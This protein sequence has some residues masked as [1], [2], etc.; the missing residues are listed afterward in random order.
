[1]G[2]FFYYYYY[3]SL[4]SWSHEKYIHRACE[5]TVTTHSAHRS[6][7]WPGQPWALFPGLGAVWGVPPLSGLCCSS[8]THLGPSPG[9]LPKAGLLLWADQVWADQVWAHH[10]SLWDVKIKMNCWLT[11]EMS[12]M[13]CFVV[14]K[15]NV[16]RNGGQWLML[17][18]WGW[19]GGVKG[20]ENFA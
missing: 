20:A 15:W 16:I 10:R 4:F 19:I 14:Q 18:V 13:S 1:M 5:H 17:Q 11:V 8:Q 9:H 2:L 3:Y 7:L 12:W 6:S